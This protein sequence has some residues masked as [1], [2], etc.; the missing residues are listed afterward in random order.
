MLALF[1]CG[2]NIGHLPQIFDTRSV[3]HHQHSDIIIIL[4]NTTTNKYLGINDS[5]IMNIANLTIAR[6]PG[7]NLGDTRKYCA[8]TVAVSVTPDTVVGGMG[9]E[10]AEA[11]DDDEAAIEVF[12]RTLVLCEQQLLTIRSKTKRSLRSSIP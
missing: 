4:I 12:G 3:V 10:V 5:H 1:Q 7:N 9:V 6:K 11:D 8:L 2:N